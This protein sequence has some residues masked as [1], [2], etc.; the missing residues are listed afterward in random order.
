MFL[1][2]LL[3]IL[4]FLVSPSLR[5]TDILIIYPNEKSTPPSASLILDDWNSKECH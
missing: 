5:K 2:K 4:G 1:V 3:N